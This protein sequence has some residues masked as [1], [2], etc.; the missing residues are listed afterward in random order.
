MNKTKKESIYWYKDKNGKRM[1]AYRYKYYDVFK[2]RREKSKQGF[3]TELEAER[4]LLELKAY[5]LDGNEAFVENDNMILSKWFAIWTE[6]KKTNWRSG[7]YDLYQRH[8]KIH[9]EPR[10]GK[11]KLNKITNMYI[12]RELIKPLITQGLFRNTI[13]SIIGL[14]N[15]ALNSAKTERI[16]KENPITNIDISAAPI[17]K[18]DNFLNEKDLEKLLK[19]TYEYDPTTYYTAFL[20]LAFTG[21]RKGE[22]AG[23]KWQDISFKDNTITI[24]RTRVNKKVG[25]PK[26]DNGFRTIEAN[27]MLFDQLKKYKAWCAQVM[28]S[29]NKTLKDDDYVFINRYTYEPIAET[30]L[31]EALNAICEEHTDLPEITPHGLRHTYSSILIA[32]KTPVVTVAKLIGDHPATVNNVYAHSLELAEKQV[33]QLFDQLQVK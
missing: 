2:K 30:Y 3:R 12:E 5:I 28:W 31:N 29:K 23:L 15:A 19:Y 22:L 24:K 26:S 4:A 8:F 17:S 1:Y 25:P 7:T 21:I 9:I 18:K 10:I 33:V 27:R 11:V 20:T 13:K 6:A 32:N 16:I 14:L